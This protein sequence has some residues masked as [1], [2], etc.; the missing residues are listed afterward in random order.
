MNTITNLLIVSLSIS[1]IANYFL[2][3]SYQQ[4][5][6]FNKQETTISHRGSGRK[7]GTDRQ[8]ENNNSSLNQ[9]A[10]QSKNRTSA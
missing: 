7:G 4:G 10:N 3:A 9:Y 6:T 1:T 5:V 2:L 8:D